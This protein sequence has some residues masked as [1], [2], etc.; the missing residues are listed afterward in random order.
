METRLECAVSDQLALRVDFI[1]LAD[2]YGHELSAVIREGSAENVVPLCASVEGAG[3]DPWPPSPPLQSLSIE[4]LADGRKAALLV[5]MAGKS[6]WSASIAEVAGFC[7]LEFD[8]ACRCDGPP[9]R[10]GCE[11][12]AAPHIETIHDKPGVLLLQPAHGMMILI[13]SHQLVP[14]SEPSC[15]RFRFAASKEF[16]AGSNTWRW[17]YGVVFGQF[18]NE[19]VPTVRSRSPK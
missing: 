13:A 2:R 8:Y 1:K 14:E 4:K 3:D 9:A 19:R 12:R 10:L 17:K 5:G 6:H 15:G 18:Q 11:Y 16:P 7:E